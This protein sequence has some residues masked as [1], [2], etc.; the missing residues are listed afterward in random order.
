MG[1][2]KRA[3]RKV[4]R[5][6][7]WR[8]LWFGTFVASLVAGFVASPLT[9]PT[10]VKVTGAS[11]D[12]EAEIRLRLSAIKQ[13]PSL[14]INAGALE[15][16][17]LR[18]PG[19]ESASFR[20][21]VFGRARLGIQNREAVALIDS[22]TALDAGGRPFPMGKRKPPN[23]Q[24]SANVK[25]FNTII[26]I[27][28]ASPVNRLCRVAKKIKESLPKLV[29]TL[30]IDDRERIR[31]R[32]EDLVVEFGD[33]SDLDAKVNILVRAL[34]ENPQRAQQGG[35]INLVNPEDPVQV[36]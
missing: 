14:L 6:P 28:D 27:S 33:T 29:G 15:A 21:N 11:E 32:L 17:L 16:S 3:K 4:D 31:L 7:A 18:A 12:Q 1:S 8:W 30:E 35:S 20:S 23:L 19:I 13:R 34:K 24:I 36:R 10:T 26:T 2:K 25:D 9:R 5:S 22:K